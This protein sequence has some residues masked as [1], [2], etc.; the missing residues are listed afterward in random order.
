MDR[1]I[2]YNK[3]LKIFSIIGI[4]LEKLFSLGIILNK[5]K[6]IFTQQN[7]KKLFSLGI[8]FLLLTSSFLIFI[9]KIEAQNRFSGSGSGTPD[10][11]YVITNAKQLFEIR[12]D[13]KAYYVLGNDINASE[14]R[15]WK[16]GEGFEPIGNKDNPFTGSFDG[17]GHKIYNLYINT[18]RDYVGLFGLVEQKGIIK[19]VVLENVKISST[20]N[21]VGGLI[22][23]N[24]GK[25]YNCYSTG[26][27][28]GKDNVGGLIGANFGTVSNCYS[29]GSI[30]GHS[31][32]GGLIGWNSIEG[33]VSN[34]YST[35]SVNGK[36]INVGGLIGSNRGKVS[37][38]YSTGSVNG[39][40]YVGGL[41]GYNVGIVSNCY[42]TGSVN[43]KDYVGG[44]IGYNA[45]GTAS[46]SFWDIQTSGLTISAGGTGKTTEQMK[47]VRTYTDVIWSKGLDSPW[48]FVGNPYDD[49]GNEDIWDIK[50]NINN[51]YPYLT[52]TPPIP[53]TP[54]PSPT[55]TTTAQTSPTQTTYTTT[56]T[57]SPTTSPTTTTQTMIT[58]TSPITSPTTTP[59][60]TTSLTLP[61]TK[62][63]ELSMDIMNII[64]PILVIIAVLVFISAAVFYFRGRKPDTTKRIHYP[65]EKPSPTLASEKAYSEATKI[66]EETISKPSILKM[67]ATKLSIDEW[68]K[69]IIKVKGK[70][71]VS[72]KLEGDVE[73]KDPGINE[74]SGESTIE[75]PV[76]PKVSGDI[77]VKVIIDTPYGKESSTI[78]LKVE[79]KEVIPP[80]FVTP[81]T[82]KEKVRLDEIIPL[83]N[84]PLKNL[85][86]GYGCSSKLFKVNLSTPTVPKEFEGIWNCCLLGCGGWGCAYLATRGNEKIVIKVPRGFESVIEGGIEAPTSHEALL[87]KIRSET[88]IM[89]SLSHPNIIKFLGASSRIP[90]VI[91][92]FAD[93]GSLYWQLIKG[94]RPSL[95]DAVLVGIQLGDALRYIHS[96]GLIH[97]DIKPS[98]VFIKNGIAKLGDFSS[99]V[100]LL[101]SVSISKLPYTVGF[102]APE[103]VY[104][105]LK[106]KAR[107]LGVENRIDI[108]QLGNL[109][110]Y[111][112]TGESIDGEDA[113][114][115]KL[116]MEKLSMI[117]NEELRAILAETLKLEPDKRPSAEEFTKKLYNIWRK[118]AQ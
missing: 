35:S 11:P 20:G 97:G 1:F 110:L 25:I 8:I 104:L 9:P 19:N 116:V 44:L 43:G 7:L 14:T 40:D 16:D 60:K 30:N 38:C 24:A 13:L 73:W 87:K 21:Y 84:I 5:L 15:Y 62:P 45:G 117:P 89:G 29:T 3:M 17:R 93:Y 27:V 57:T 26:S 49:K 51:G 86:S 83:R 96:R 100:K 99:T 109:L 4:K 39:K 32:V 68:G 102:R 98:N 52:T 78:F 74:I 33:I 42:S 10:D 95:R 46:N 66:L 77:P 72:I 112:L 113:D 2:E 81:I 31:S 76:K 71:K 92:E 63:A 101:S 41:I 103:Q 94:W 111:I 53:L 59:P 67:E 70:G 106:R 34:S 28:N 54:S 18:T 85:V 69:I 105:E 91:Y 115:E 82:V 118:I 22:G 55:T 50:P 114:D 75:I 90:L 37:N 64:G 80:Q 58:T 36:Y 108:Y 107:E 12:Y 6:L 79:R 48:D 88:E 56:L 23:A 65:E 61:P 47:N